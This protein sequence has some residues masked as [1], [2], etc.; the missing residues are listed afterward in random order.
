MTSKNSVACRAEKPS[1]KHFRATHN[2]AGSAE[3][4]GTPIYNLEKPF[5]K[6]TKTEKALHLFLAKSDRQIFEITTG[7]IEPKDNTGIINIKL[8]T[9]LSAPNY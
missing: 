2:K 5:R 8:I 6:R 4:K 9:E 7:H 3:E 1:F